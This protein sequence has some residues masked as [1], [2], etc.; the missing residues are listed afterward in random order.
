MGNSLVTY[1]FEKIVVYKIQECNH[2]RLENK[3]IASIESEMRESRKDLENFFK[4]KDQ[5]KEEFNH[6][7]G[8]YDTNKGN[9]RMIGIPTASVEEGD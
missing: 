1:L 9:I 5:K 2:R 4:L 8:A 6:T 7:N 3:R